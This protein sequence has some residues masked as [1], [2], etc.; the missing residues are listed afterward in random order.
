MLYQGGKYIKK[1]HAVYDYNYRLLNLIFFTDQAQMITRYDFGDFQTRKDLDLAYDAINNFIAESVG[2]KLILSEEVKSNIRLLSF[3]YDWPKNKDLLAIKLHA[4]AIDRVELKGDIAK[5]EIKL[6]YQ[7]K[8]GTDLPSQALLTIE[9]VE[10][11][12]LDTEID[13]HTL[14]AVFKKLLE[15]AKYQLVSVRSSRHSCFN[16]HFVFERETPTP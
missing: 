1:I 15:S 2:Y 6:L 3:K 10:I 14:L 7:V 13:W 8:S 11:P 12:A 16:D 9:T 5:K 4:M